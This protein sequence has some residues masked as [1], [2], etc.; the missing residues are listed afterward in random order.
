[1]I[2]RARLIQLLAD[3]ASGLAVSP[4]VDLGQVGDGHID[5]RLGPDVIVSRRA[6]GAAVL[7]PVDPERFRAA[8]RD[9]HLY[10]R[11][12]LGDSFH[13]QPGEFAIARSLEYVALPNDVSA[14]V[15]GR[16]S[17]GRLGL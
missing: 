15:L 1:M 3:P 12:S 7:D 14:E 17:W 6:V 5:L 4:L 10:V 16:S 11:R 13:L 2:T 8:L 9:R